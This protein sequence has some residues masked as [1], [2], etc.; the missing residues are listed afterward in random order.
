LAPIVMAKLRSAIHVLSQRSRVVHSDDSED[1]Y[2]NP[3]AGSIR[4]HG[5]GTAS[6]AS[7][8]SSK[9]GNSDESPTSSGVNSTATISCVSASKPRDAIAPASSRA[10]RIRF[11][12][13]SGWR[14]LI[15]RCGGYDLPRLRGWSDVRCPKCRP[16]AVKERPGRTPLG[17]RRFC[18]LDCRKKFNERSN[19]LL[20]QTQYRPID[21]L[22]GGSDRIDGLSWPAASHRAIVSF[23]P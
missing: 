22:L 15:P 18:Y 3:P 21:V 7:T 17:Y 14:L 5:R 13:Q 10:E 8:F 6:S 9:P 20:N 23:A 11:C 1:S 12:Q 19:G 16:T 4:D 2:D